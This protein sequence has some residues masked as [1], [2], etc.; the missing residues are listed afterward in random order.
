MDIITAMF[1]LLSS[2]KFAWS[3]SHYNP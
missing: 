2:P 3:N 1:T